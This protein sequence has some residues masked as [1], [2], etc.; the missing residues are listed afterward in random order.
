MR[1]LKYYCVNNI[2]MFWVMKRL[3]ASHISRELFSKYL[4]MVK[5]MTGNFSLEFYFLFPNIF[6]NGYLWDVDY[7]YL[8]DSV[9][10]TQRLRQ[11]LSTSGS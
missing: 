9:K 6:T 3:V 8:R 2:D 11:V 10:E 5:S 1:C 7:K 4:L